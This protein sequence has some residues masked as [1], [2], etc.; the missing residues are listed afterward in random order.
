V[1]E[2][3]D[4]DASLEEN[5]E[6]SDYHD[7]PT[8]AQGGVFEECAPSLPSIYDAFDGESDNESELVMLAV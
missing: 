8:N 1:V 6:S 7:A 5:I 3:A 2:D 4:N